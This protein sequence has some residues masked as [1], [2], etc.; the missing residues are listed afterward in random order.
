MRDVFNKA[1]V[2]RIAPLWDKY[3][4][5]VNQG[6]ITDIR[7]FIVN[8]TGIRIVLAVYKSR[9]T[10]FAQWLWSQCHRDMLR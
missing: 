2:E 3:M 6:L 5:V 7:I 4:S 8:Q 10:L 1:V 9:N